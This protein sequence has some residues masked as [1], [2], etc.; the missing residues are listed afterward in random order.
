MHDICPDCSYDRLTIKLERPTVADAIAAISKELFGQSQRTYRELVP[1]RIVKNG[2]ATIVFWQDGTK[3]V[4]KRGSDEPD[5]DYAA[6]T[7]ALGIKTFGSNSA[8]KRIVSRT[9]TQEKKDRKAYRFLC[10]E[11][12]AE[13][14][15]KEK[16]VS[17]MAD[18]TIKTI[19]PKCNRPGVYELPKDE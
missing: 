2:V 12:G 4:V 19:C 11:C 1:L 3:T 17:V 5:S 10:R 6:F 9:E 8:L 16:A 15:K 14:V 7:A 13:F 18:N